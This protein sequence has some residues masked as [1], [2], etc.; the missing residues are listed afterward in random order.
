MFLIQYFH[1]M[2]FFHFPNDTLKLRAPDQL[3]SA[4]E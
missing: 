2:T 4:G 1:L 3:Q